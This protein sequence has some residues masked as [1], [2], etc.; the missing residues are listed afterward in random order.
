M[1]IDSIQT[2]SSKPPV[3]LIEKKI[4]NNQNV[5]EG[6]EAAITDPVEFHD[7]PVTCS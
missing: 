3:S 4:S 5:V 7:K 1:P 6:Y 2:Y